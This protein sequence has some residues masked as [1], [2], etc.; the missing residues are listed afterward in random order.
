M[1]YSDSTPLTVEEP[2]AGKASPT[3]AAFAAAV[4]AALGEPWAG[5]ILL[6]GGNDWAAMAARRAQAHLRLDRR[7]SYFSHAAIV[8]AWDRAD[9]GA[10]W[11]V[12]VSLSPA[13]PERHRPEH[14]GVTRFRLAQYLD[15]ARFPNLALA[16]I[17]RPAAGTRRGD[18]TAAAAPLI[19][20]ALSPHLRGV[21][22]PL[23]DWIGAWLRYLYS[24][25]AVENPLRAGMPHPGAALVEMVLEAGGVAAAPGATEM[26]LCPEL[27]WS[28]IRH[29]HDRVSTDESVSIDRAFQ[30]VRDKAG[31]TEPPLPS[32][33][34]PLGT[35]PRDAPS[36]SPARRPR[37]TR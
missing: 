23:L 12:E 6:V 15:D 2:L 4:G 14:N 13:A 35:A 25:D 22:Y 10:S 1:R 7:P 33:L 36:P 31:V 28:T 34:E 20:A 37:R 3:S 21:R 24:G 11:G 8:L 30:L 27:L 17:C 32:R 26:N 18:P 16:A 5:A 19:D 29:W 9:P